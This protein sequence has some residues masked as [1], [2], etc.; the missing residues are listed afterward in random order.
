MN[1]AA[2]REGRRA[3]QGCEAGPVSLEG[4]VGRDPW[5]L[6]MGGHPVAQTAPCTS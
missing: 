4:G 1:A 3:S 5:T 2:G 6:L